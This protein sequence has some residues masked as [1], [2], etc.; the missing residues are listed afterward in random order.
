MF[1]PPRTNMPD[2]DELPFPAEAAPRV[3]RDYASYPA[4]AFGYV[5]SA[6]G[7]PYACTFCE[8]KAIWTRTTRWRSPKTWSRSSSY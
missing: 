3:L 6:R 2:L 4:E 5:F 7:C 1:T 8:S